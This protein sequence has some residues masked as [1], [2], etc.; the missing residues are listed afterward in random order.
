MSTTIDQ[1]VVQMTFDNR[2]FEQ[3]VSTTM[4]T[5]DRLKEK[6]HLTGAKRGLEDVNAAARKVDMSNLG[7]SVETV[8]AK[9]SA[10]QVIGTTA[11]VN[12]TNSAINAGKRIASALTIKPIKSGFQEYETQINATQT[13]YV[14]VKE[15]G[16]TLEDVNKALDDLNEY[17]D[18]TIYNF[19]EMTKNI[20]LFVNAGVGLETSVAAIKGFSNAAAMAGTN[21]TKTAA[22]MYQL[23]QAMSSGTVRLMDWRSLETANIAGERFKETILTTA[24]AHGIAVDDMIKKHGSFR[25]SLKENWLSADLMA[26]ALEH[27]TLSTVEMTEAEQEAAKVRL[28]SKG[29]TDEQ[30][31][32]LF[33]LGTE[34]NDAATK[35]KTF[36][37][38]WEVLNEAAQSGW[39]KTW[40]III[41]DFEQA[42]DLLSPIAIALQKV[43]D[44]MSDFRNAVLESALG[45]GFSKLSETINTIKKPITKAADAV[46]TVKSALLDLDA[47]A[48]E[49][50]V[51]KWDNGWTRWDALTEAGYNYMEVQNKVN[52]K[53]GDA[54]RYS[55]DQIDAQNELLASKG[56]VIESTEEQVDTTVELTE[57]DAEYIA[58]LTKMSDAQLRSLGYSEKQ[59]EA[60]KELRRLSDKL[61]I[62]MVELIKNL[63]KIN[64]RWLL[65]ESFKNI[66][67]S[68]AKV[69]KA[70]GQAF[71]E[72]FNFNQDSLA[73]GLF[74]AIAGLHKFSR[75]ILISDES[76][77]NLKRTLKGVFAALDLVLTI[78]S[79]PVKIAFKILT[80]ILGAFDLSILDV[81]AVIG[82]AIVKFRDWVK[83]LFD[84]EWVVN[85]I[86]P[87]LK[88]LIK[89]VKDWFASLK[90]SG[91][92]QKFVG[93]LKDCWG[94]LK[95]VFG[96]IAKSAPV[97]AFIGLVKKAANAV[98]EWFGGMD[99]GNF[100]ESLGSGIKKVLGGIGNWVKGLK[101]TDDVGGYLKNSLVNAFKAIKNGISNAF[102]T[103]KNLLLKI[104]GMS[105]VFAIISRCFE[106]AGEAASWFG[107]IVGKVFRKIPGVSEWLDSLKGSDNI[108]WDILR[109]L[110]NGLASGVKM[111]WNKATS[112]GQTI[113]D[114]VCKVLGI[115]SPSTVFFAIGGFIIAGLLAGL[116]NGTG[117]VLGFFKTLGSKISSWFNNI[118][119]ALFGVG[120]VV[121]GDIFGNLPDQLRTM[122][123]VLKDLGGAIVDFVK[124]VDIGT[125]VALASAIMTIVAVSKL[126]SA[127]SNFSGALSD[128][129]NAARDLSKGAKNWL[130][131]QAYMSFAFAILILAAALSVIS[132]ISPGK[133]W[134]AVGVIAAL[135]AIIGVLLIVVNKFTSTGKGLKINIIQLVGIILQ[136]FAIAAA[137]YIMAQAANQIA[138][139]KPDKAVQAVIGMTLLVG[140]MIALMAI[141]KVLVGKDAWSLGVGLIGMAV[142]IGLMAYIAKKLSEEP[143]S[144]MTAGIDTLLEFVKIIMALVL[145]A[146]IASFFAG[147]NGLHLGGTLITAALSIGIMALMAKMLSK[148]KASD[149]RRGVDRLWSFVKIILAIILVAGIASFFT[150]KNGLRLGGTLLAVSFTILA[151]AGVCM[152]LSV[153]KPD[154]L[155]RGT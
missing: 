21:S 30:I 8:S 71:T 52:E 7:S 155:E 46:N 64:G 111:V 45:K 44:K 77:E 31:E 132:S 18:R 25:D 123:G 48:T 36:T 125:I 143:K 145:V 62:P 16:K 94:A 117:G 95:N 128:F 93:F 73:N 98:R 137:M 96:A 3:N 118:F 121:T 53:M 79:G 124:D 147:K 108:A 35:V 11:L 49:V 58:K 114:A 122:W 102:N 116:S 26:E 5:L 139:I 85:L 50:I 107:G 65:W 129:G 131:A 1:Q 83:Q 134:N 82:D 42:K 92:L 9:F 91:A 66:G 109:G 28:K 40:R 24:R 146:G 2:Q 55:Q 105:K 152:L 76:A 97:Q 68:I 69:F 99:G 67:L 106:L 75:W 13:I 150:G 104:P 115:H 151:M 19:T 141:T 149:I 41:G 10:L 23:S 27:Y 74:N 88:N 80:T 87:P 59:I 6:L 54:Y 37:Q 51:G 47:I 84:V 57:A 148:M 135:V 90:E 154:D 39:A 22:A 89:A 60:I 101:E 4:S 29:Y 127:I 119:K 14:N 112:F 140:A 61:G 33:R 126:A 12:I 34:A 100:F 72:A 133:L 56:K 144:K 78:V 38:L 86:I 103:I 81:T 43:I 32:S 20:G 153:L 113:I 142:S 136:V 63:D 15:K 120:D 138:S 110:A 17:A 130:N 70:I